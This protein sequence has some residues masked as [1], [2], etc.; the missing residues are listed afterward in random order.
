MVLVVVVVGERA[1]D[2]PPVMRRMRMS[3][4]TILQ[5]ISIRDGKES[6]SEDS[7]GLRAS[8]IGIDKAPLSSDTGWENG[9]HCRMAAWTFSGLN[10][11]ESE[12]MFA[13]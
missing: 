5:N 3:S 7:S 2:S 9:L 10:S 8:N 11:C 6:S 13:S 12:H 1:C 4:T